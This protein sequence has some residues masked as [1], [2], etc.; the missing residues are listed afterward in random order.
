[1]ISGYFRFWHAPRYI[2]GKECSSAYEEDVM[3]TTIRTALNTAA[4]VAV[5]AATAH[6]APANAEPMG[7]VGWAFMGFVALI[8]VAQVMPAMMMIVGAAM[9]LRKADRNAAA[10]N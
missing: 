3:R 7:L 10:H 6:A 5:T 4:A 8:V 2:L 1:V 9:G